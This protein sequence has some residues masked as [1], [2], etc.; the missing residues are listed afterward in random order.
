MAS[1]LG[2]FAS[3]CSTPAREHDLDEAFAS[4]GKTAPTRSSSPPEPFFDSRR[5]RI[6]ALAARYAVPMIAGLREYV[7]AGGLMS[8]GASLPD[9]YRQAGIYVGRDSQ[10]RE[11]G[12]PAGDAADQVRAWSSTSRPPRRS[13]STV[14]PTLLA[15]A[16]EVIE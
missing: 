11:A 10:G 8:Y 13:A 4:L 6:V 16:D 3:T 7:E 1:A 2:G 5:D 9:S 15:L 12:R 14:P